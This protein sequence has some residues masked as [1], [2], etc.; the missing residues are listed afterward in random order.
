MSRSFAEVGEGMM[1]WSVIFAAAEAGGA[2]WY[3]VE[4]DP[5]R[6]PPLESVAL[7]LRNRR[8]LGKA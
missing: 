7:S 1:D 4:P 5:C 8:A 2:R 6:R 3:I